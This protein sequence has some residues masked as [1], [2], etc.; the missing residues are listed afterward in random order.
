MRRFTLLLAG[1]TLL[2]SVPVAS[3]AGGTQAEA[4]WVVTD[5]GTLGGKWSAAREINDH[6]QIVGQ[7]DDETKRAGGLVGGAFLWDEGGITDIGQSGAR[8]SLPV[9]INNRGQV[10]VRSYFG[11]QKYRSLLWQRGQSIDLGTLPGRRS[12]EAN[13]INERGQIVGTSGSHAFLWQRGKMID[14]GT[15]PGRQTSGA[16]A[17]NDRGQIVG[18]SG[19]HAV[20]WQKGRIVDLG[21][22]PG[23]TT[24]FALAINERGQVL[25]HSYSPGGDVHEVLW[26]GGKI[27]DLGVRE[28]WSEAAINDRGQIVLERPFGRA[29]LCE[30]GEV[31]AL[32]TL[33]GSSSYPAD[34][35]N[36]GQIV[37][38]SYTKREQEDHAFLWQNGKMTDLGTLPG[39]KT[40]GAVAINERGQIVGWSKTK[41]GHDRAVLW[42]LKRGT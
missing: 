37:G 19:P 34:I 39:M 32:G 3:S 38:H 6:G 27:I 9:A 20:L 11:N 25:G 26:K 1:F 13:A 23:H 17:M 12:C 35:N 15:L 30:K 10:I 4:R 5:L 29:V 41:D 33:G 16:L 18:W 7:F 22:L 40:S 28:D 14:L 21:T 2:A 24:S 31:R 8:A 36:R 42:T